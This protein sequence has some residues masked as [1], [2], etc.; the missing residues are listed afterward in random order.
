MHNNFW[1]KCFSVFVALLMIFSNAQN[2]VYAEGDDSSVVKATV[3]YVQIK[4]DD[5]NWTDL[6]P[7][8]PIKNG[9]QLRIVGS[10]QISNLVDDS[11]DLDKSIDLLASK[12]ISIPNTDAHEIS[13]SSLGS[14]WQIQD[15]KLNLHIT[16]AYIHEHQNITGS[17]SINGTV[18]ITDD[19]IKNGDKVVI[20]IG[21]KSTEIIFDD[22]KTE[23]SLSS[24]KIADGNI[25]K[26]DGKFYQNYNVNLFASN[27]DATLT[28]ITDVL[29][30]EQKLSSEIDVKNTSTNTVVG[31]Y[32]SFDEIHDLVIPA[33]NNLVLS[34]TAE[35]KIPNASDL[36]N[37]DFTNVTEYGNKFKADYK[38]NE[39]NDKT[40]DE[41]SALVNI[42]TPTCEKEGKYTNDGKITWTITIKLGSYKDLLSAYNGNLSSIVTDFKDTPGNG[43]TPSNISLDD[44]K[45]D[46]KGSGIW[47]AT[48]STTINQDV[49]I[50]DGHIFIHN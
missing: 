7:D 4:G 49:N 50:E 1:K 16:Q 25:Y 8:T 11:K 13:D 19:N 15:G 40:T 41:S 37:V 44:F 12:Y 48:Y 29:G 2:L 27:G 9:T 17:F 28:K 18:S 32:K 22:G 10:Y 34:Y 30:T 35:V 5:E 24:N 23:S 45:E 42:E 33:G 6:Q 14:T 31:S 43:L 46:Q 36:N 38:T 47:K 20:V 26:K 39:N 21:E 3:D